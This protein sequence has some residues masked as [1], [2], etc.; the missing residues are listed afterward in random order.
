MPDWINNLL[1]MLLGVC[2]GVIATIM[3]TVM[4]LEGHKPND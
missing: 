4:L 3:I 2:G 1:W